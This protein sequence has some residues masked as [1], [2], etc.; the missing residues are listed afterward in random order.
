MKASVFIELGVG[1]ITDL[2]LIGHLLVVP[3]PGSRRAKIGDFRGLFVDQQN[4]LI[5]MRF[6]LAAVAL[7]LSFVVFRALPSSF[8]AINRKLWHALR[9]QVRLG[10]LIA[11]S[12]RFV[13]QVV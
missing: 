2:S 12:L 3:L 11:I 8:R 9:G 1:R 5:G 13:A 10:D 4:V 6:L 7:L